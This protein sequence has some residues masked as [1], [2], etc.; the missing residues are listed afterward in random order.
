[1]IIV[2]YQSKGYKGIFEE[3]YECDTLFRAYCFYYIMLIQYKLD[4]NTKK[5]LTFYKVTP[6]TTRIIKTHKFLKY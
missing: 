4:S 3:R 1:M 6:A 2:N 5:E